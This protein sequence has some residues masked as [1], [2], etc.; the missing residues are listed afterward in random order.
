M[1][2]SAVLG[3]IS[4]VLHHSKAFYNVNSLWTLEERKTG[5]HSLYHLQPMLQKACKLL[6]SNVAKSPSIVHQD[7]AVRS[8]QFL[9]P[10]SAVLWLP[11]GGRMQK[12]MPGHTSWQRTRISKRPSAY[13]NLDG[14]V[15]L[16]S[17]CVGTSHD[18]CSS[19]CSCMQYSFHPV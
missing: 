1:T 19:T 2:P 7:A 16:L 13:T 17:V 6:P 5:N 8:R 12:K 15:P 9:Q 11:A 14:K 4:N 18:L 10:E 3:C